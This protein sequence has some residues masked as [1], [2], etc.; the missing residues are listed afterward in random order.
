MSQNC[1]PHSP[2]HSG[3]QQNC[4]ALDTPWNFW[5]ATMAL[6]CNCIGL[7]GP[8]AKGRRWL[9]WKNFRYGQN[10]CSLIQMKWMEATWFSLSCPTQCTAKVMFMVVYDIDRVILYH[11]AILRQVVNAVYYCTFL[12]HLLHPALRRKWW[13]LV[14]QNLIVLHCNARS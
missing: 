2:R 9:S 7:V 4:C 8:V 13:H 11:A 5:G 12:Q 3:L 6:L 10:L 1:A 14:V